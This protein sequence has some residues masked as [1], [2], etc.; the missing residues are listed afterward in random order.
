MNTKHCIAASA[1]VLMISLCPQ[2][3]AAPASVSVLETQPAVEV[4]YIEKNARDKQVLKVIGTVTRKLGEDLWELRGKDGKTARV[5]FPDGNPG[6]IEGLRYQ[7]FARVHRS[8]SET[9]LHAWAPK[10]LP[11]R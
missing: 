4:G 2:T 3:Q 11:S 9:V 10:E 6:I 7:I 5:R 8:G 1:A